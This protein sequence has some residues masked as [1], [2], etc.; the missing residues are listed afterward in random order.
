MGIRVRYLGP[1][2]AL[3]LGEL[4]LVRGGPEVEIPRRLFRSLEADPTVRLEV[5]DHEPRSDETGQDD[6]AAQAG[7]EVD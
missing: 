6:P 3:Q 2:G 1:S 4:R 5:I 7:Q